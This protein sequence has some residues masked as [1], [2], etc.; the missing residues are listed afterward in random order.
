PSL[1]EQRAEA[2]TLSGQIQAAWPFWRRL[3]PAGSPAAA[4]GTLVCETVLGR[5]PS[6]FE[7]GVDAKVDAEFLRVYRRLLQWQASE[8]VSVLNGQIGLLREFVP[9]S[10]KML[11]A[12]MAEAAQA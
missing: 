2:L 5:T 4:V 3:N 8:V 11:E 10:A 6:G 7:S 1:V 9:T 12:A